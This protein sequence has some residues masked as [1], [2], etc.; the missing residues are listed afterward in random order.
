VWPDHCSCVELIM[1]AFLALER[2]DISPN[3]TYT[4]I[5]ID[6][7]TDLQGPYDSGY[8]DCRVTRR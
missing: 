7:G 8:A 3:T 5:S 6:N 4:V 1:Q 2:P